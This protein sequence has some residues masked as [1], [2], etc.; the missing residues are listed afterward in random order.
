MLSKTVHDI[1][2]PLAVFIG[3]L[4]ILEILLGRDPVDMEIIRKVSTKFKSS[5][6]GFSE[7]LKDLRN[8]YKV[9]DDD[10]SFDTMDQLLTSISYY[11]ENILYK[12]SIKLHLPELGTEIRTVLSPSEFFLVL[13]HL[14]QNAIESSSENE[15]KDIYL[16]VET[17]EETIHF[18]V[19]D[20]GPAPSES[21]SRLVA[22]GDS[23][24]KSP[25]QGLG[26][27][28]AEEILKKHQSQVIYDYEDTEK[29]SFG[30]IINRQS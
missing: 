6:N 4:S 28:I 18:K 3:Q 16:T 7:R 2:N 26:L 11:F 30:F 13:K 12:N 17:N 29:K 19:I 25:K 9:P 27:S 20:E 8:F 5:S 24:W 23:F 14:I 10:P 22:P 21:L 15:K 1:N